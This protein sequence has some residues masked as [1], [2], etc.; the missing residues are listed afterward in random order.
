[1]QPSEAG[2]RT[3]QKEDKRFRLTDVISVSV[4][5]LIHDIYSS[6]LAPLL[7][8]LIEKFSLSYALAGLLNVIQ[9]LP[10]LINP[11][12]GIVADRVAVRYFL[13]LAPALTSV[14][15]SL[16]GVAPH[17]IVLVVLLFVMGIGST[18]FH[19]P[20][21]VMIKRVAG[22][23]TGAGMSF[24]MFGGELAR[25]V[26]PLVILGAVSLWGLEGTWRLIPFGLFASFLLYLRIHNIRI[27]EE[28]MVNRKSSG[29]RTTFYKLL[30]FFLVL[31]AF[32]FFRSLMKAGLTTFLP[33]YL[34]AKG[35]SLWVG[36]ISLSIVQLS[37]AAGTFLGG[38][39]SDKIGRKRT[40][41][42]ISVLSPLC[43]W[44]FTLSKGIYII[45]V[46]I[47]IGFL[48]I[49]QAPVLLALVQDLNSEHPSFVNGVYMTINFIVG[50]IAVVLVGLLGD[51]IGLD[52]TYKLSALLGL[53]SI[54]FIRK[55]PEKTQ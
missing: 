12:V 7:P 52:W 2:T 35:S 5:H 38:S 22:E 39:I 6:F 16:L 33:T 9:R 10:A 28:L 20:A 34:T 50:A 29:F 46:L 13:I 14:S 40:L 55:L 47:L 15:M 23:R 31:T 8:L 26:G 41:M 4:G 32:T 18:L 54:P 30:P 24:Y 37:G 3:T 17:Y 49:A 21:P 51:W 19:V 1:M 53:I 44:I 27:S 43:M 45:P 11:F 48:I 25:T 36:G 42:I